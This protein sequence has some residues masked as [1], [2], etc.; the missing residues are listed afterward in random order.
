MHTQARL[1]F[2]CRFVESAWFGLGA[3]GW[4]DACAVGVHAIC[5]GRQLAAAGIWWPQGPFEPERK[6]CFCRYTYSSNR[7]HAADIT[8]PTQLAPAAAA[9]AT[10]KDLSYD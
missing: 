5:Q 6:L 1:R 3:A 4:F 8:K 2:V 7:V 9:N 10:E